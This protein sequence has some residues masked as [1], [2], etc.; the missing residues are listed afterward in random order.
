M[1]VD[2][3]VHVW[4]EGWR[5]QW[6]QDHALA[7]AARARGISL[8]EAHEFVRRTWDPDASGLI[9]E[10]D[11]I[12]LDRSLVF[13]VDYGAVVPGQDSAVPIEEQNRL[14]SEIAAA[15]PDRITW[16]ASIDPRR[17]NSARFVRQA[18][19]EWGARGLKL[20]C[21]GGY[22]PNDRI[23]YPIYEILEDVGVPVMFHVGP[24]ATPPMLSKYA[25][26]LHLEEVSI[27]FPGLT[28]HAG[29]GGAGHSRGSF[30]WYQDM[31]AIAEVHRNIVID[32]ALWQGMARRDPGRF[33]G[34][35][36]NAVDVLGPERVMYATDWTNPM[37]PSNGW[38]LDMY[39]NVPEEHE[40]AGLG[41]SEEEKRLVLGGNAARLYGLG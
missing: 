11:L 28:I 20:Y 5:P 8:D 34:Y 38:Y 13:R 16:G 33:Y 30:G 25:H 15:H 36:R 26:P 7:N 21:A 32:T 37:T 24:V 35:L 27:D 39:R 1:I 6:N 40:S 22:Y 9:A 29:H 2:A 41:L 18:V 14:T 10:M 4:A 19:S 23:V 17:P 12:G 31:L 3:H